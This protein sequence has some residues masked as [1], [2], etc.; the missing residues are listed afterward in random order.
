MPLPLQIGR[1]DVVRELGQGGMGRVLLAEDTVLGR[2]VA[3]KLLRED[4]GLAPEHR[5]ALF[6]R[7]RH[8][9]RAAALI[10]HP[11]VVTLHDMGEDEALGLFLVFEYVDGP[12]LRERLGA[13]PLRRDEVA[14]LAQELGGAL[15]DAHRLGVVHRDVKPENIIFSQRGAKITDFGIARLPDSTLTQSGTVLGTPAY[16]APESLSAAEF[17]GRSDQ[18]AFAATLYEALLGVRAFPGSDP[19]SVAQKVLHRTPEDLHKLSSGARA[20]LLRALSKPPE[21][22]FESCAHFGNALARALAEEPT[23]HSIP[24][25]ARTSIVPRATRR[26]QNLLVGV[27]LLVI[28]ALVLIGRRSHEDEG[29]VSLRSAAS[30]FAANVPSASAKPKVLP[31]IPPAIPTHTQNPAASASAPPGSEDASIGSEP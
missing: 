20:V 30:A 29:G 19:L 18:F 3:V 28:V 14:T 13:G 8:E 1:Y 23:L 26:W 21:E 2:K 31:K 22:R 9:A 4:L 11:N 27:A 7:M 15:D 16:S 25:P 5:E 6:A 17:S 10:N 24:V 12:T